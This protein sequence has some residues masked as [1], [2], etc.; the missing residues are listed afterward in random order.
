MSR[1][2]GSYCFK[3]DFQFYTSFVGATIVTS[4]LF[5]LRL[6]IGFDDYTL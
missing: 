3:C 1:R 5:G 2:L 4:K 6:K